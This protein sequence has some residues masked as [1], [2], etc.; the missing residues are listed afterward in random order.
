S[1]TTTAVTRYRSAA[2]T[3]TTGRNYRIVARNSSNMSNYNIYNAKIIVQQISV[4]GGTSYYFDGSD[5][6]VSDPNSVWAND[7]NATNGNT[8][9]GANTSTN[10]ST[11]SNYLM[12]EG[13]TSP[14]SGGT[15]NRVVGAI[16]STGNTNPGQVN[17]YTNGL[18]ELLGSVLNNRT[19]DGYSYVE[20]STPSG[21][22][23]WQKLNDLEFKA[24]KVSGVGSFTL[25]TVEIIVNPT[26]GITKLEP[27]Y[28]LANTAVGAGTG[29]QDYDTYFDPAEWDSVTNTYYHEANNVASGTSDAKLQ[30]DPNGTPADITGSTI[31]DIIERERSS[32]LTMPGTAQTIDVNQTGT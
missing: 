17:I 1:T 7:S 15:I 3:P 6:A 22:W 9:N 19:T 25:N 5:V 24:F 32:S 23:T 31:T 13:T 14:T 29:L 10:G 20:L 27:Q 21:G 11:S 30:T 12:A 28:L 4:T 26:D 18:G 16:Y 8:A 2:F